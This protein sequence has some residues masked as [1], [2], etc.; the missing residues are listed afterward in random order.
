MLAA[1]VS[2]Y[3]RGIQFIRKGRPVTPPLTSLENPEKY[4]SASPKKPAP[5]FAS[6]FG[7]ETPSTVGGS[8][9]GV[10]RSSNFFHNRSSTTP[11]VSDSC[12]E[13]LI[14]PISSDAQPQRQPPFSISPGISPQP[15]SRRLSQIQPE[16]STDARPRS[17]TPMRDAPSP[18]FSPSR[19]AILAKYS[20]ARFSTT[21]TVTNRGSAQS[22]LSIQKT[23]SSK[24][25]GRISSPV[26]TSFVH[27]TGAFMD[28]DEEM[29]VLRSG[30]RGSGPLSMNPVEEHDLE[31]G[32]GRRGSD[33]V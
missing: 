6:P 19:T 12:A 28:R 24:V 22:G 31:G 11:S 27:V 16:T 25:R 26:P 23:N 8:I 5:L 9:S 2:F 10:Y 4:Q 17:Y 29:G 14:L 7:T 13:T 18:P 30:S 3:R 15:S 32:M 33:G 20:P 21:P 1:W